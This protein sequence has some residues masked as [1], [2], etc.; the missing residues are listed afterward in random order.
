VTFAR[1][2]LP[3]VVLGAAILAMA[4]PWGGSGSTE[5]LLLG[6]GFGA[7]LVTILNWLLRSA[8]HVAAY[9]LFAFLALRAIRGE[10]ALTR[11]R[12]GLAF[13]AAVALACLDETIQSLVPQRGG[14]ATDVLLDSVGA[15][16]GVTVARLVASRRTA[17]APSAADEPVA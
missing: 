4:G 6:I 3:A 12:A 16:V 13:A 2:T 8:G 1:R 11:R 15:A 10:A 5:G 7:D 17:S 14:K 9:A